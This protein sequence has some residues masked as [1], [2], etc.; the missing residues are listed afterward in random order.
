MGEEW[1]ECYPLAPVPLPPF[2]EDFSWGHK[3]L[4]TSR[5][6]CSLRLW[7][8]GASHSIR[9]GSGQTAENFLGHWQ[10]QGNC[11]PQLWNFSH[12]SFKGSFSFLP[13]SSA[14]AV[15]FTRNAPPLPFSLL[16]SSH[17]SGLTQLKCFSSREALSSHLVWVSRFTCPWHPVCP[18][19]NGHL[20]P[21]SLLTLF[22]CLVVHYVM[23]ET[24][25]ACSL[26]STS[27]RHSTQHICEVQE[28]LLP[29]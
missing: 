24:L 13:R 5:C 2:A 23:M 26:P 4:C 10:C 20:P 14:H 3:S 17:S 9:A 11:P 29:D 22:S 18:C 28:A 15:P 12:S 27:S 21:L 19:L 16:T 25:S 8:E 1:T 7:G 6:A